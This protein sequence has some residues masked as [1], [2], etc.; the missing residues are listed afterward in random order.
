MK[1]IARAKLSERNISWEE[2]YTENTERFKL[3][4]EDIVGE[5][6]YFRWEGHDLDSGDDYFVIVGPAKMKT[7]KASWFAGCRKLPS[8]WAAG[9]KYFGEIKEAINYANETWGIPIPSD[10]SWKYDSSDL[11]GISDKMDK[12][13]EENAGKFTKESKGENVMRINSEIE[14]FNIIIQEAMGAQRWVGREGYFWWDLNTI[15]SDPEFARKKAEMP[16]LEAAHEA[17]IKES[18]KRK[19]QISDIYGQEYRNAEFYKVWI[20]HKDDQG[21]YLVAVGPYL[22]SQYNTEAQARDKFGFFFKK[23]NVASDEEITDRVSQLI[24]DY[25]RTYGIQLSPQDV[26]VTGLQKGDPYV[27]IA[28]SGRQKLAESPIFQERLKFYNAKNQHQA[29]QEYLKRKKQYE[30]ALKDGTALEKDIPPLPR[31]DLLKRPIG[32]K[33]FTKV[34]KETE[35]EGL[36]EVPIAGGNDTSVSASEEKYG[37]ES[38]HEAVSYGAAK[39]PKGGFPIPDPSTI[40]QTTTED[41]KTARADQEEAIRQGLVPDPKRPKA[42]RV[43]KQ[44]PVVEQEKV[45]QVIP[46]APIPTEQPSVPV[47]SEPELTEDIS[48]EDDLYTMLKKKKMMEEKKVLSETIMNL[49]KLAAT[50][51]NEGKCD[52]AEEIHRILRKHTGLKGK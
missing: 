24:E 21:T 43:R 13:R 34:T 28:D 47:D 23:L 22:A 37:F 45:E 10:V 42:R 11:K 3:M 4:Y 46:N 29:Y 18:T 6:S 1:K 38:L 40:P 48:D 15:G 26:A 25:E 2:T 5:G 33:S 16:S 17:L 30:K 51:D 35:G 50:L 44:T 14:D 20:A 12:W 27:V 8:D 19:K 9:G 49:V 52:E 32:Q 41:L 39:M 7:P 31:I 36:S